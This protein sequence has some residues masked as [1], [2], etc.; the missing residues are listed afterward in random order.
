MIEW[1]CPIC[2]TTVG[3]LDCKSLLISIR[4]HILE[5]LDG[6]GGENGVEEDP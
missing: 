5:H 2:K 4:Y 1:E 3:A 6:V